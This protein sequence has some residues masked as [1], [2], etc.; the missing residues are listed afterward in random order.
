MIGFMIDIEVN[1]FK[2]DRSRCEFDL[3]VSNVSER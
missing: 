1:M 3:T 2:S